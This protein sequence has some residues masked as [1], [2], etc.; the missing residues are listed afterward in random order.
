M[1]QPFSETVRPAVARQQGAVPTVHFWDDLDVADEEL[2]SGLLGGKGASLWRLSHAGLPVAPGFT[3]TAAAC[4]WYHAHDRQW[5]ADLWPDV[6]AAID[7]LRSATAR[8]RHGERAALRVAVRSGAA[9]SMPGLMATRLNVEPDQVRD[10]VSAVFDSWDSE[11]ARQFRDRHGWSGPVGT[12]VSIQAMFPSDVSGVLFTMSPQ[13]CEPAS[14][15]VEAVAGLGADLVGG[16]ATPLRWRIDRSSHHVLESPA[17]SALDNANLRSFAAEGLPRLSRDAARIEALFQEPVDIEFGYAAGQLTYFQARPIARPPTALV[18]VEQV[19]AAE[20]ARLL[21][22]SRQGR[23]WWIRHNLSETLPAP[24]PLTWDVWRGFMTGRGGFGQLYRRLGYR[25]SARVCRGGF[26]EL[27]GGRIYADPDRLPEMF[28]AGYPLTYD[29]NGACAGPGALERGPAHLDLERLDPWFLLRWPLVA[30]TVVRSRRRRQRLSRDAAVRFHREFVPRLRARV[31]QER[32]MDLDGLALPALTDYFESCRRW[33]FHELAPEALL[34]GMLGTAA[35][36]ALEQRLQQVLGAK[37]ASELSSRLLAAIDNPVARRQRELF[38]AWTAGTVTMDALLDET[39]HRGPDEM[40]L[41]APRWRERPA[42]LARM[43]AD[44]V[45]RCPTAPAAPAI[46]DSAG[47]L[48]AALEA[49]GA[50]CLFRE[51]SPLLRD[52][53]ALL[54]FR[55]EGKHEFLRGYELLRDTARALSR[56]LGLGDGIFYLTVAEIHRLPGDADVERI[57]TERRATRRAALA[58]EVPFVLEVDGDLKDFGTDPSGGGRVTRSSIVVLSGG[59]GTGKACRLA[60]NRSTPE[61]VAGAVIVAATI[62]PGL[63][64]FLADVAAIVVEQGGQ[65]SHV[66]LLARQLGIPAVV[67]PGFTREVVD[68]EMVHVD[69]D[70]GLI[71]IVRRAP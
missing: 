48:Q 40:D 54:P 44:A 13:P 69:A 4:A 50:G 60:S 43:A 66:A 10:A 46:R 19:R 12:A 20:R 63:M 62:E 14:M 2:V 36:N 28:C 15:T 22:W 53:E 17:P 67:A 21:E 9:G 57:V 16:R 51:L 41:S 5:P 55:D 18:D 64:P 56:R 52:A 65:L 45:A 42:A 26:L 25:P 31:A 68:G 71:E 8:E 29:R 61:S 59:R 27:I 30:W 58:L 3:I 38:K 32:Q 23:C 34:P 11:P 35:W 6:E 1:E 24:T 39:G 70:R 37:T 33:V 47:E 49:S 7:R